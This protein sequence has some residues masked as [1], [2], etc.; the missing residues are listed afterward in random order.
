[1]SDFTRYIKAA[2]LCTI[3]PICENAYF[4][5]APAE[6]PKIRLELKRLGNSLP[7]KYTLFADFYGR[8]DEINA[9][10]DIAD[11]VFSAFRGTL[12]SDDKVIITAHSESGGQDYVNDSAADIK[13]ITATIP[14]RVIVKE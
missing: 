10:D 12:Y 8:I 1:M 11:R 4:N 13:H 14:L 2:V 3:K 7:M 5:R 6:Y 9:L